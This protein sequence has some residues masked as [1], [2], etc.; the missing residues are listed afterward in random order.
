M[1]STIHY[2]FGNPSDAEKIANVNYHS[3]L[4]TYSGLIDQSF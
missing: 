4:E 3:W 2:R 1:R